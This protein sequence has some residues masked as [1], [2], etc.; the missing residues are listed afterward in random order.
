MGSK[1]SAVHNRWRKWKSQSESHRGGGHADVAVNIVSGPP[2][3][4]DKRL[5]SILACLVGWLLRHASKKTMDKK[6]DIL[7]MVVAK[8]REKLGIPDRDTA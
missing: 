6:L 1:I 2:S 5:A 8:V 7:E 3:W 4:W